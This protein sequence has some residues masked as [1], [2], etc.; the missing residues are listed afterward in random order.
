MENNLPSPVGSGGNLPPR[1]PPKVASAPL[2]DDSRIPRFAPGVAYAFR[3]GYSCGVDAQVAGEELECIRSFHGGELRPGD[4]VDSARDPRSRLHPVF[5][6]DNTEAAESW[7]KH[8][9]RQ[10]ISSVRVVVRALDRPQPQRQIAYVSVPQPDKG[11]AY[12][13]AKVVMSDEV[14]RQRALDEALRQLEAWRRRYAHLNELAA[15]FQKVDEFLVP[16][17]A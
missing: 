8:E 3:S 5:T 7:R 16:P 12:L 1:D 17:A 13:P 6:W 15:V 10:L 11:R 14:L 9:A 2:G 4:V